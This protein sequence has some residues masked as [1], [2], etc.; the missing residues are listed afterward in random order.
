[1]IQKKSAGLERT[2]RRGEVH[3]Q[4]GEADVLDHSNAGDLVVAVAGDER[5][6]VAYRDAAPIGKPRFVDPL[7]RQR[8]LILAQRYPGRVDAVVLRGVDDEPTPA[9]AD[10]EET[11]PGFETQLPANEIELGLLRNVE[12]IVRRAEVGAGINHP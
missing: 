7:F 4:V 3:G 6:I 5:A 10:V 12:R 11:L 9:A 1:M 2:E 8:C